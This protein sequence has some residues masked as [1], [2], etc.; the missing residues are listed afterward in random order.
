MRLAVGQGCANAYYEHGSILA[1]D[2]VLTLLGGL[3]GIHGEQVFAV[4]EVYVFRQEWLN[5]SGV[6]LANEK[7]RAPY[8]RIN[9]AHGALQGVKR[10]L[11]RHYHGFPVPLVNIQRVQ[12]VQF[13]VGSY[14]V[15]VGVHAVSRLDAVV[16]K[17]QPFP[18]GQRV[19]NLRLGVAKILDGERHGALHAV[20]VVVY[21]KSF[22]HEQRRGDTA[23]PQLCGQVHLE[24]LFYKL[25]SLFRLPHVKQRP[26]SFRTY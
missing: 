1:A 20:Q 22:Q 25:Y 5:H 13:L 10:A 4:D 23:Q 3:A 7:F 17:G 11:R 2:G 14:G 21:A 8:G 6:A 24:E 26:V 18:L 19:H 15:H 16:G 9:P 12:V